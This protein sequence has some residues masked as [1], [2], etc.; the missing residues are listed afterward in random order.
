MIARMFILPLVIAA[1]IFGAS[2][3]EARGDPT[4]VEFA[5]GP[6]Q[7]FFLSSLTGENGPFS[8]NLTE[9][10]NRQ[11][12]GTL[13][14]TGMQFPFKVTIG[15]SNVFNAVGAEGSFVAHGMVTVNGDGSS[16]SM[17][18]Y[19]LGTDRGRLVF[20]HPVPTA[21]PAKLAEL[22]Q[23]SFNRDDGQQGSLI[24]VVRQDGSSFQGTATFKTGDQSMTLPYF[25]TVGA[26]N[27]DRGGAPIHVISLTPFAELTADAML[28]GDG[29][30]Q[31]T[32]KVTFADGSVHTARFMIGP[33]SITAG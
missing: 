25:A 23:G 9:T 26:F 4:A 14:A 19:R 13:M 24:I 6:Y 33:G 2:P 31:G 17:S 15:A 30:I 1:L 5:I 11:L 16:I 21:D 10:H 22:Y 8:F 29:S 20:L 7:G 32:V 27:A 3:G 28:M 18:N 12:E